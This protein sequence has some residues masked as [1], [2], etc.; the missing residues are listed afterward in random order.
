M[1][2]GSRDDVR[3]LP[4]GAFANAAGVNVET[5]RFYQR[6]G[7]L[8]EPD[9]PYG[10]IRRYGEGEVARVKFIKSAQRLGFSLDEIAGLL[11]LEDGRHC[12]EARVV[13]EQKLS[14]VRARLHDLRRIE[15]T[16]SRLVDR[17]GKARGSITCP[18]IAALHK[19]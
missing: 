5:I 13:A 9:R 11:T 3:G 16:L 2:T 10:T 8:P 14:D 19:P 15:S 17:C 6:K 4:I 12:S 7:L 18:L 1:S